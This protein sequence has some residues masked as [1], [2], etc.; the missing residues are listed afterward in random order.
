[1]IERDL[2]AHQDQAGADVRME[3]GPQ[4]L[5]TLAPVV[6]TIVIV[7]VLSFTTSVTVAVD[8]GATVLPY[9]W[10]DGNEEAYATEHDA[11]LAGA[12][13]RLDAI[14]LSPTS[15]L[16]CRPGDR[17]VLPS[18]NGSALSFAAIDHGAEQVVAA[19]L[20]NASAV[21]AWLDRAGGT[22]GVV[23]AGERWRGGTGPMRVALE[24]LLGAGALVAALDADRSRSPESDAASAAFAAARSDLDGRLHGTASGRELVADG[25]GPDVGVAAALDASPT[26]PVLT[27]GAFAAA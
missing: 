8:A 2:A 25:F 22:V 26:V 20:R 16:A 21:A 14:S 1:M 13:R 15:L 24:D 11:V 9:R 19:C 27:G 3:W 17:I 23:P 6:D 5:R 12:P 7:D 18:A 4:G 10:A